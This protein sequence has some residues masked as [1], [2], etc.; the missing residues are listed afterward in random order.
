VQIGSNTYYPPDLTLRTWLPG[1][2]IIIGKYCSIAERVVISTGGM[3]RTDLPALYPLDVAR[4]YQST[5]NTTIGNDVWIG[6]G[7]MILA[8]AAVGDG[9]IIA[10]GAVVFEDVPPFAVAAGNPA[11]ILRFRF[12]RSI[13]ERL[14]RIAWWSWP[15]AV[16]LSNREWFYRPVTEFVAQFDPAGAEK[17]HG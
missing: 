13:V 3:R 7:A 17:P 11:Q 8:G 6:F 1:E 12:S 2:R 9:A 14:L 4:A 16:V 10:S 15:D 5:R